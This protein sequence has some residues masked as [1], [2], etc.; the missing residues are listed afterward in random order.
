MLHLEIRF[1]KITILGL[2]KLKVVRMTHKMK[3]AKLPNKIQ[4][5]YNF[6]IV[7]RT[8]EITWGETINHF[9]AT[10]NSCL[11]FAAARKAVMIFKMT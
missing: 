1:L 10:S 3:D 9:L 8:S 5:H 6:S 11:T 7:T 2:L 4:N